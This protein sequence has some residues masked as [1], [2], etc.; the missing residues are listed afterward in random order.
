[1]SQNA[2]STA[3]MVNKTDENESAST[4][5]YRIPSWLPLQIRAQLWC[6]AF[7]A[8]CLSRYM[9][10]NPAATVPPTYQNPR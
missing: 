5:V 1:M 6:A 9:P 3:V 2:T 4:A 8:G 7:Q 10:N